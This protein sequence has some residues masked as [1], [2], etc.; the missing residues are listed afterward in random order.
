MKT[1]LRIIRVLLIVCALLQL[2]FFVLGWSGLLAPGAFVQISPAGMTQASADAL[3]AGQ[4]VAGAA[5]GLPVL[6]VLGY[7][8]WRL[9]CALQNFERRALFS[10]DTIA[11]VRAFAGAALLSTFLA[12][13]EIPL[14]ALVQRAVLGAPLKSVSIGVSNDQL[15]LVLVCALFYLLTRLMHEA[16]RLAEENEGFV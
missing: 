11:H 10:L 12:I 4:R 15:L 14:R 16:R 6:L 2:S 3:G 5:A 8:L 9:H 1:E 7:G 13:I